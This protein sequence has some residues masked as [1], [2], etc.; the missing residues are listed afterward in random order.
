MNYTFEIYHA[1][2]GFRWRLTSGNGAIVADSGEAYSTKSNAK[3][4]IKKLVKS[5]TIQEDFR[6]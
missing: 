5:I 3:R 4:A 2:D 1:A 6:V